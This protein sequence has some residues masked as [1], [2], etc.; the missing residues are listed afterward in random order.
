MTDVCESFSDNVC[1]EDNMRGI[2]DSA[3][4]LILYG[5]ITLLILYRLLIDPVVCVGVD[6]KLQK[7]IKKRFDSIKNVSSSSVE[8]TNA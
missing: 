8:S 5:A 7:V 2:N 1:V 4:I 3:P 6:K